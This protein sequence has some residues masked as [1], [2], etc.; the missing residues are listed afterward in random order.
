MCQLIYGRLA[1]IEFEAQT[2]QHHLVIQQQLEKR[3]TKNNACYETTLDNSI[4]FETEN[5]RRTFA[6]DK[7]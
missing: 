1:G 7:K 5:G 3:E 6:A 2:C 4:P